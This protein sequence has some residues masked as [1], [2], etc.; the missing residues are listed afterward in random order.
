MLQQ[1]YANHRP[2]RIQIDD[3]FNVYEHRQFVK[4]LSHLSQL[5]LRFV[6]VSD[7]PD[8]RIKWWRNP[9][10]GSRTIG[11]H[12]PGQDYV[13]VSTEGTSTEA[14][15]RAIVLHE[16]Q[17][18]GQARQG[19]PI[20]RQERQAPRTLGQLRQQ[21]EVRAKEELRRVPRQKLVRKTPLTDRPATYAENEK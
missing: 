21:E 9:V 1:H 4:A 20:G 3:R 17:E 15:M 19:P 8:L 11:L 5:N 18:A 7:Y 10:I 6:E 2:V 13:L 16:E 12:Y 14:Q